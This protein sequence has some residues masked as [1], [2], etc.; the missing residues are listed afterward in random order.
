[1]GFVLLNHLPKGYQ[2][3]Y[4]PL[5][6]NS[7]SFLA[8]N[9][10]LPQTHF[11]WVEKT[12]S[13]AYAHI[14]FSTEESEASSPLKAP[15]GGVEY[16]DDLSAA[17]LCTFLIF[18]EKELKT[19][20]VKYLNISQAPESYRNQKK[21]NEVL[22][23]LK[24]KVKTKRIFHGICITEND[25]I[26]KMSVMEQRRL[27]KCIKADFK[28]KSLPKTK[29]SEVYNAIAIWRDLKE[30]PLS[31]EWKV[32]S[33]TRK[34]NP[35]MYLPFGVYDDDKLIAATIAIQVNSKVLYH[36]YPAHS[37]E[38]N[39]FSP[40]VMLVE[41]LYNWCR[42][43]QIELLDLGTSYVN[44]KMNQSLV[45]FKKHLG[46]EESKALIYRKVLPSH[47]IK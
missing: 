43:E 37:P 3:K 9:N 42:T 26:S 23:D 36:F 18:V 13:S 6:Y 10:D 29:L 15:F 31:M 16:A 19:K 47:Q 21:L 27:K 28:F 11:Y 22:I 7:K 40:M 14:A 46:G 24:Y 35:A 17:D 32:L 41:G 4:L 33:H 2:E 8:S 44:N 34:S 5:V 45:R 25:I 1:M 30:K 12:K 38:Y 39:N 20:S